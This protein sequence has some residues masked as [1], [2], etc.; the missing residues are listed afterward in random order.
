MPGA[1]FVTIDLSATSSG[2][3]GGQQKYTDCYGRDFPSSSLSKAKNKE[4][5]GLESMEVE[6]GSLGRDSDSY[7]LNSMR[8]KPKNLAA[9]MFNAETYSND[10]IADGIVKA[11]D[12]N[13]KQEFCEKTSAH[14]DNKS[15]WSKD[16][17]IDA[18][19]NY[20]SLA[21]FSGFVVRSPGTLPTMLSTESASCDSPASASTLISPQKQPRSSSN[22][23]KI[24]LSGFI[25]CFICAVFFFTVHMRVD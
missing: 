5:D 23:S 20:G 4:C 10:K 18:K 7:Q 13:N 8:D 11:R 19:S 25:V 15:A 12:E 2:N 1:T 6:D 24:L 22:L 14:N 21:R 16:K 9:N 17:L 3:P